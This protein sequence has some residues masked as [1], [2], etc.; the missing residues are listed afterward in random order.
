ML[1]SSH[2]F[3]SRIP[4]RFQR[5][6]CALH[7]LSRHRH[8]HWALLHSCYIKL[9]LFPR[10]RFDLKT[11]TSLCSRFN[12]TLQNHCNSFKFSISIFISENHGELKS[13][14]VRMYNSRRRSKTTFI[15]LCCFIIKYVHFSFFMSWYSHFFFFLRLYFIVYYICVAF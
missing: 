10:W 5:S 12:L 2:S 4:M 3:L 1:F 7:H 13:S 14:V 6:R 8:G 11:K 9:K 15:C